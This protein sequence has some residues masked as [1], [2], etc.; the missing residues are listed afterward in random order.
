MTA[1]RVVLI[2]GA[3]AP[4]ALDLARAFAAAGY[5]VHMADCAP[6]RMARWSRAP[7]AVHAY[8]SPVEDPAAFERDLR[9]LVARLEPDL[10]LP[11]C[12]EVFHLARLARRWPDLA[13]RLY[14]P[15]FETL[16]TLHSKRLFAQACVAHGLPVPQTWSC[17]GPEDLAVL[18]PAEALVFKPEY[19]RFGVHTLI[20]PDPGRLA[21]VR[22]TPDAPWVAQHHVAGVEVSF[23]AACRDGRLSAFCAYGSRWRERGGASYGF[24]APPALVAAG[25]LTIAEVLARAVVRNGQFACDAIIDAQ[26]QAWLLECNPRATSGVHLFGRS[27]DLALALAGAGPEVHAAQGELRYLVPAYWLFGLPDAVRTGRLGDWWRGLRTGRDV[28]GAPGDRWPVLGAL[29]D[30][31]AFSVKALASGRSLAAVMTA[32]IEWNGAEP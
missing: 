4:A 7:V 13:R 12:E 20:Q 26:G 25:L 10:I 30:S 29:V 31:L 16:R 28:I 23:Y 32:D 11:T 6:C 8:A 24:E 22:P 18:P 2:T 21:T 15:D 5:A 1:R 14:A 3:R 9:G 19:S 17:E 27:A